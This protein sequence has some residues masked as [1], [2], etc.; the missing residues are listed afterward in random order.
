MRTHATHVSDEQLDR[1]RRRVADP[2]ELLLVDEHIASCD[3]CY[4]L[5]RADPN[6]VLPAAGADEHLEYEALERYVDGTATPMERELA[7]AHAALCQV[8]RM[9][10]RDLAG[11]RDAIKVRRIRRPRPP[12]LA[13][14]AAAMLILALL[15]AWLLLRDRTPVKRVEREIATTTMTATEPPR[16]ELP[17]VELVKPVVLA[18]LVRGG[19]VLRGS[20]QSQSFALQEPVGTVV[21][22]ERPRF[23]WTA[24]PKATSYDVAVIDAQ[25]GSI[26]ASGSTSSTRWQP[27]VALPRG[28]IYSWQV[29]AHAGE[30]S[31]LA[32]GPSAPEAL[33]QVAAH[34]EPL[35][36]NAFERGVV[37]A[38]RGVLDDAE[39]ELERAAR[40]GEV[41]AVAV[42]EEVR[43]WRQ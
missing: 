11:M 41:R 26:A 23:R 34:D 19:G 5:V 40:Q 12:V 18:S 33:F 31:I 9:E 17:K 28:R 2:S 35:P 38:N 30:G 8:C 1:Y 15:T 6:V 13:W 37:L 14:A 7:D 32:P 27:A 16:K 42:L 4:A 20:S 22:E 39:R 36:E 21:V 24:A 10:L 43:S 25:R 3:R 29:T